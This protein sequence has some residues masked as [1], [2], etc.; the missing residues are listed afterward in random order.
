M[1]GN[2]LSRKPLHE[3]VSQA[4]TYQLQRTYEL[5]GTVLHEMRGS[6]VGSRKDLAEEIEFASEGKVKA[7]MHQNSI[8]NINDIFTDLKADKVDGR[9]VIKFQ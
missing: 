1:I 9:I 2:T 3:Q 6:I 8:E 5:L 7:H 4:W